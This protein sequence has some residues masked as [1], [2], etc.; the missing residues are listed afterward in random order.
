MAAVD[1]CGA[2]LAAGTPRTVGKKMPAGP[3]EEVT[4]IGSAG[5]ETSGGTGGIDRESND[6]RDAG[7]PIPAPMAA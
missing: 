7:L 2:G 5:R 4:G 1:R 3:R 6:A